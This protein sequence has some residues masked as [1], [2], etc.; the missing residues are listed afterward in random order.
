LAVARLVINDV[1]LTVTVTLNGVPAHPF[2]L[3]VTTYTT[4]IGSVVE[5]VSVSVIA[6][7]APLP[8]AGVMFGTEAL[9][10]PNVAVLLELVAV[11]VF[12]TALHQLAVAKLVITDIGLTVTVTLNGVPA[13]PLTLGV[14]TYTTFI[15]SVVELVSVSVIVAVAPLPVAGAI[16]GTDA[17]VHANV[18][19]L[20]ELVAVYVL[21]TA[22]HQLAVA[23]LVINDVGF[24][25][26]VTLNGVP[27]HPLTFGVI[28]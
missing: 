28:T 24:T 17:L 6:A 15:G 25:V 4:L 23:R 9:V 19:V 11:Y 22:L 18:A 7:V 8:V 14:T 21:A 1:G 26:T 20:L 12:D 27:A 10:H 13:H 3:G 2:T 5:F 16:L